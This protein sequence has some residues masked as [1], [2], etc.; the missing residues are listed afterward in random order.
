M[1]QVQMFVDD[2]ADK[3]DIK[4][5]M[6]EYLGSCD[7]ALRFQIPLVR[8]DGSLETITC[9]RVQH[10]FHYQPVLGGIIFSPDLTL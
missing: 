7:S 1:E 3:I 9:Y 6:L 5:D 4:S 8:D 2:A 10:K